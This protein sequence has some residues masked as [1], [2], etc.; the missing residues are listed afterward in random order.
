MRLLKELMTLTK[1][2]VVLL[3][4][5][6]GITGFV[7]AGAGISLQAIVF[8]VPLFMLA[9]G[10]AAL[11]Q[12]QEHQLDRLMDR[13]KHRPIP[14][15]QLKPKISLIISVV[16]IMGG[17]YMLVFSFG[18]IPAGLGFGAV[19]FYNGMYTYLKRVTAFA[20]VPGALVGALPP[21]VGWTAAGGAVD[22]PT[23]LGLMFFFY[24]WQIPHFW[25]FM[26]IHS[27]DYK[28]AG[29][30]SLGDTFTSSQ[31]ARIT[32]TWI[33]ATACAGMLFPL[34]GMFNHTISFVLLVGLTIW[35]GL[36]T[37]PLLKK[38]LTVVPV[39]RRAFV[40]INIFA[41]LIM[42]ILIIDHGII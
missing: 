38:Q 10:S 14:A 2:R 16:L 28:K 8:A 23:L 41:L 25:L 6:S 22:S 21:A 9:S 15:G 13:T 35:L 24:L 17:L 20:A 39:F 27:N 7:A 26:G 33:F 42:V 19:V 12:Y 18:L 40:H 11:N 30:P 5:F 4:T 29:F 32:F 37:L 34:F 36:D 3:S 1:I 31:L